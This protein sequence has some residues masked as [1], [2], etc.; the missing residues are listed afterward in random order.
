M[1]T[2]FLV[3]L[4]T[5]EGKEACK[6]CFAFKDGEEGLE[7]D[8]EWDAAPS[9]NVDKAYKPPIIREDNEN[10][11]AIRN[12]NGEDGSNSE[13]D[14]D[15]LSD[16]EWMYDTDEEDDDDFVIESGKKK[17]IEKKTTP[18]QC[19]YRQFL[20]LLQELL[21]FHAWYRYGDPPFNH[22]PEQERIDSV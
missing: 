14:D 4:L 10:A 8:Y 15:A 21:S 7:P 11:T 17:K 1:T 22:N 18:M 19:S 16:E 3:L 5:K 6:D 20:N 12:D 2:A 9:L 13:V